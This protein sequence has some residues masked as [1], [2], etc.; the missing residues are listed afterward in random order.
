M[1]TAEN[2]ATNNALMARVVARACGPAAWRTLSPAMW[3]MYAGTSGSTHGDRNE[4]SP[5]ANAARKPMD[6]PV[7]DA[8]PADLVERLQQ[9]MEK[10]SREAKLHTSWINPNETYDQ[11]M[12][13]FVEQLLTGDGARRFLPEFVPFAR[14]LAR[15]GAAN[16]LSQLLIK[17]TAPGVPDFYQ[18]TELWDLTLVDPDNRRP[19]DFDARIRLADDLEP[20]VRDARAGGASAAARVSALLDSWPDGRIKMFATLAALA[21]RRDDPALFF[22]GAYVPLVT[23][24]PRGAAVLAFARVLDDRVVIAIAPALTRAVSADAF[25]TGWI[26]QDAAVE[27]PD[28]LTGLALVNVLT[29]ERLRAAHGDGPARLHLREA[30]ATLPIALLTAPAA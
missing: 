5:A 25:A 24:E 9:Y 30:L 18:G 14:R 23:T 28:A 19:I 7:P 13:R 12:R 16:S 3:E 20:L 8:A 27:L 22:E 17:T 29:G 10:A 11:A 6:A 15:A 2:P 21:L 1:K 26:W 4:T